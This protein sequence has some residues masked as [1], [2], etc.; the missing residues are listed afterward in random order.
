[1]QRKNYS[2]FKLF[3]EVPIAVDIPGTMNTRAHSR[4]A[5]LFDEAGREKG[6]PKELEAAAIKTR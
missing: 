3:V 4:A 1:M 2:G 6:V 5:S